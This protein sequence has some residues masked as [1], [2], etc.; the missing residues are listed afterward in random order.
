MMDF[1]ET[2]QELSEYLECKWG[3]EDVV[4]LPNLTGYQ[5]QETTMKTLPIEYVDQRG[6][7]DYGGFHGT[8]LFP[9]PG[10]KDGDG[11]SPYLKIWFCE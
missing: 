9:L 5:K 6:S 3:I 4:F 1:L 8:M 11:G 7:E 2:I 10:Y